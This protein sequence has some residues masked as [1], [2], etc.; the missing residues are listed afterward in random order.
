MIQ[1]CPKVVILQFRYVDDLKTLKF[2]QT[3]KLTKHICIYTCGNKH[4][5]S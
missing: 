4:V 3:K 5:A 2:E 1:C